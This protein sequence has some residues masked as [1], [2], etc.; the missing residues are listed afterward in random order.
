[1]T[2][3][4][5]HASASQRSG[6]CGRVFSGLAIRMVPRNFYQNGPMPVYDAPEIENAPL[7]KLYLQ[8][9]QLS[10]KIREKMPRIG[11]LA[12]REMLKLTV[13]PPRTERLEKAIQN[14]A[15]VGALTST[16]DFADITLLGQ[17][18]IQLPLDLRQVRLIYFG[19][20][21]GCVADAV[22]MACALAANDPFSMPSPF[23]FR[24]RKAFEEAL[25]RSWEARKR[26]DK[27]TNSE[28]IMLRNLFMAWLRGLNAP[29][30]GEV[31]ADDEESTLGVYSVNGEQGPESQQQVRKTKRARRAQHQRYQFI[32]HSANFA[33]GNAVM[34]KRLTLLAIQ[35]I[36]TAERVLRFVDGT[37]KLQLERLLARLGAGNNRAT[38]GPGTEIG[39]QAAQTAKTQTPAKSSTLDDIFVRDLFILRAALVA[40]CSPQFAHGKL[41][42]NAEHVR[43]M[44]REEESKNGK[45]PFRTSFV[46]PSLPEQIRQNPDSLRKSLG[47][48]FGGE[49]QKVAP[50]GE[51]GDGLVLLA[52]QNAEKTGGNNAG[53]VGDESASS[54]ASSGDEDGEG[55][56][57]G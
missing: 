29:P 43:M 54:T 30:G 56:G 53:N 45:N 23:V 57:G 25:C 49:C 27:N 22:V 1:M 31:L 18:A 14:L 17:L 8:V 24:E 9:K 19:A 5:S 39:N 35:V 3:W 10:G 12:P 41:N 40:S 51:H 37:P 38:E 52:G 21:F 50:F 26:F 20:L 55:E 36:D 34:P 6:R 28:P 13:Q 2:Q 48:S 47:A 42:A 16:S 44:L 32:A 15:D 46:M 11:T 4:I 33:R 7:E